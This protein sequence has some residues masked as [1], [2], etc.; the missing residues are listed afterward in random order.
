MNISPEE[1]ANIQILS[2]ITKVDESFKEKPVSEIEKNEILVDAISKVKHDYTNILKDSVVV[3]TF[4]KDNLDQQENI[5]YFSKPSSKDIY[6]AKI[7]TNEITKEYH[8]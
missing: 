3:K 7:V 2:Q 6:E 8:I 1:Q 5:I 4:N